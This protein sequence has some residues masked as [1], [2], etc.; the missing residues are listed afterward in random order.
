MSNSTTGTSAIE[1]PSIATGNFLALATTT[2]ST[3]SFRCRNVI[4]GST[5]PQNLIG[6]G[7]MSKKRIG[8]IKNEAT[9]R[10]KWWRAKPSAT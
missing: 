8:N 3:T 2:L 9:E 6:Q 7:L 10:N 1:T 5:R 4:D